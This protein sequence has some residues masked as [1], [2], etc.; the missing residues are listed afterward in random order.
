MR[1]RGTRPDC[2]REAFVHEKDF[3]HAGRKRIDSLGAGVVVEVQVR[4]VK[5]LFEPA[6]EGEMLIQPGTV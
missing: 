2:S 4:N 1:T 3:V 5:D 6:D